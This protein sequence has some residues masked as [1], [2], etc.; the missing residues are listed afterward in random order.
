MHRLPYSHARINEEVASSPGDPR[1][2]PGDRGA[3][4]AF[5]KA[6]RPRG[7]PRLDLDPTPCTDEFDTVTLAVAGI[8]DEI[9]PAAKELV[10]VRASADRRMNLGARAVLTHLLRVI[11]RERGYDWRSIDR[12][13]NEI[14]YDRSTVLRG[15]RR[16]IDCGYVLPRLVDNY[17]GGRPGQN[18]QGQ[19]TLPCLVAAAIQARENR[20]PREPRMVATNSE[21]G[22]KKFRGWWQ[23]N[24]EDGGNVATQVL[25]ENTDDDPRACAGSI[26]HENG[27]QD[28]GTEQQNGERE[29]KTGTLERARHENPALD[30]EHWVGEFLASEASRKAV[31]IDAAFLGW[32]RG[33]RTNLTA[34]DRRQSSTRRGRAGARGESVKARKGASSKAATAVPSTPPACTQPNLEPGARAL[35]DHLRRRLGEPVT[36]LW[37]SQLMCDRLEADRLVLVAPSK[38]HRNHVEQHFGDAL[39]EA[40]RLAFGVS[41]VK[42][43]VRA[44]AR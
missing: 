30:I 34:S 35:H 37:I 4:V 26:V 14:G 33:V 5:P 38:F 18:K 21:D 17:R 15:M 10:E 44:A 42:L 13:A 6:K 2:G 36:A 25:K 12:I 7:R 40:S 29:L 43:T 31:D 1:A 41:D 19:R 9:W 24:R 27:N 20:N 32:M 11:N 16:L 39:G 8:R 23:E 3:V 22:G 28:E